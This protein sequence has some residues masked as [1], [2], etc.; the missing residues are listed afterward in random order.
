MNLKMFYRPSL[1]IVLG[2]YIVVSYQTL[3]AG[4]G[5]DKLF[6]TEDG[7]FETAG[8]LGLFATA[9]LFFYGFFRT[10]KNPIKE[11]THWVKRVAFLGFA[12]IAFFGAGEEISWGQRIFN[13]QTPEALNSVNAQGELTVHNIAVNGVQLNFETAFDVFWF[14]VVVL[15]PLGIMFIPLVRNLA[16]KFFPALYLP[17]GG[18]FLLNYLWAK[19]AKTLYAGVYTYE[20]MVPFAQAVQE[21]KESHYEVLFAVVALYAAFELAF[22]DS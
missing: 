3:A 12:L 21:V 4:G 17:I 22:G 7:Y 15:L 18:L 11:N 5:L 16:R 9:G 14:S 13:I 1:Y 8:A 19:A 6:F 2:V 20:D 10:L